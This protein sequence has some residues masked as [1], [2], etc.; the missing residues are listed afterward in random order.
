MATATPAGDDD[1]IAPVVA[2]EAEGLVQLVVQVVG[3]G[4]QNNQ[5]DGV[6]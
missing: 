1:V 2:V 4:E 6:S 5:L 3:G